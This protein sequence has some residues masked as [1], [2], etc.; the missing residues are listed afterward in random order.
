LAF[1]HG[2]EREAVGHTDDRIHFRILLDQA[3][4]RLAALAR[5]DWRRTKGNDGAAAQAE[6][7]DPLEIAAPPLGAFD[8]LIR[9][10]ADEGDVSMAALNGTPAQ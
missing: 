5:T 10:V 2:S 1:Q 8:R 7:M 9:V 4:Q 6:F 3:D